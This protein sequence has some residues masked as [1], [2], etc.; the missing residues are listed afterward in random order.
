MI[1]GR[2]TYGNITRSNRKAMKLTSFSSATKHLYIVIL[3]NPV[4]GLMSAFRFKERLLIINGTNKYTTLWLAFALAEVELIKASS[5]Y[6]S[7][8]WTRK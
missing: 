6:I 4:V 3:Y 5:N 7:L 2:L 8:T 1:F